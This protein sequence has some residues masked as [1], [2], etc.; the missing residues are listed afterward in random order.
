MSVTNN[1]EALYQSLGNSIFY[2][3][4]KGDFA[5]TRRIAEIHLLEATQIG[6]PVRIADALIWRGIAHLMQG[7]M[8]QASGCFEKA[9]GLVPVDA[10]LQLRALSY[11]I[12][13]VYE[14]YNASADRNG[15]GAVEITARWHGVDDLQP[16]DARWTSL[17]QRATDLPT[18]VEAWVVHGFLCNL[19]PARFVLDGCRYSPPALDRG[20]ML[21]IFLDPP[22]RLRAMAETNGSSAAAAFADTTSADINRRAGD[23]KTAND[24]LDR[25]LATYQQADDKAGVAFCSMLRADWVC[26]PFSSPVAWNFAMDDSSTEGSNLSVQLEADEFRRPSAGEIE[27]SRGGYSEAGRLFQRAGAARGLAAIQLRRGYLAMLEG[28]YAAAA[29]Q[30]ALARDG[31]AARED[32]RGH[33]LAQTHLA[34]CRIAGARQPNVDE[35]ALAGRIGEWGR[36]QGS[37]SFTLGLGHLLN[38]WARHWLIRQG[39]YERSLA[40]YRVAQTLFEAL[41]ASVNAAQNLVDQGVVNLAVGNRAAATTLY[42]EALDR[43]TEDIEVRPAIAANLRQRVMMIAQGLYQS[44]LQDSDADGMLRSAERLKKQIAQLPEGGDPGALL[45]SISGDLSAMLSGSQEKAQAT[46]LDAGVEFWSLRQMAQSSIEQASV[47]AP[48]Y[49]AQKARSAVGGERSQSYQSNLD[50]STAALQSVS[51]DQRHFLE[52]AVLVERKEYALAAESFRRHLAEGGADAGFASKMTELM[53]RFGGDRGQAEVRLQQ[54]RTHEQAFAVFVRV[55]AYADAQEHLRA[56]ERI[57][58]KKWWAEDAKPWQ[59]LCDCAEMHEGLGDLPSALD[60]YGLAIERLE[61][62]RSL[63]SRD[64]LK[65]A[66]ASDKGSRYLYFLAARAAMKMGDGALAFHYAERGKARALLDLMAGARPT[67]ST[68]ENEMMRDWRRLTAQLSLW[69]GL[70]AQARAKQAPEAERVIFFERKITDDEAL[71]RE[72]ESRLAKANPDFYEAINPP[73]QTIGLDEARAALPPGTTLLEYFFLGEDLL[74]WAIAGDRPT[75]TLHAAIDAKALTR[76]IYEFHGACERKASVEELA[77]ELAGTLLQPFAE[78][79]R[80]SERLIIV[81]YDAAHILPF[82]ALPFDHQPLAARC[83]VSYLPSA[84]VLRFL[85]SDKRH[86]P[87]DCVLAVGNPARMSYRPP[88]ATQ[89]IPL[90]PLQG[91]EREASFVA[92]LF[93]RPPLI[94]EQATESAVRESLASCPL[95]HFATHGI[96]S[97]EAPLNS[98]IALADGGEL[99]VYELM[100]LQLH[101]DLVVLSACNTARGETTGGDDVLG[102]TRGL[103]AAGARAAVVSLWRVNDVSTS[104]FMGHFYR[105]LRGGDEPV[106]ALQSAQNYLRSLSPDLLDRELGGLNAALKDARFDRDVETSESESP[107]EV[108][109]HPYFWSPFILVG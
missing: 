97:A 86:S 106:T 73:A 27:E 6:D 43:H 30:A 54:R 45:A 79:I 19:F 53:A 5:Q 67:S 64:D 69:R 71:L 32:W 108:Y 105:R 34:M 89:S 50:K 81:P 82:H 51:E 22:Q 65:T 13:A 95:L 47:L 9:Q 44:Y 61:A 109:G 99:T 1:V 98:S 7:E 83:A 68:T 48:L 39:D 104:L 91:A 103:L 29:R 26:A 42:E 28:D 12:L 107:P 74:A 57:A 92:S 11:E 3:E 78:T 85:R 72:A 49:T 38:R 23:L 66:L 40:G 36:T 87:P 25:A 55:K 75:Q 101:A 90:N 52:V 41:G 24:L 17:A 84:S 80:A 35:L 60:C 76:L 70:L 37:F 88:L 15:A 20:Q 8:G 18:K 2:E 16:L 94:G 63:L 59:P 33:W 4:Y 102:L 93:Q 31:F 21:Q 96:L 14:K 77:E 58:G 56:L 62:R 100:G 46:V 10:N